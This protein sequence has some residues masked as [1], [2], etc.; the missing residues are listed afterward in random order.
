MRTRRWKAMAGA[1]AAT[2]AIGLIAGCGSDKK[3]T[4]AGTDSTAAPATDF[5]AGLVSDVGK[6]NDRSFNQS[7]LEGLQKAETDLGVK[8]KSIESKAAGDYIA[9]L[10]TLA[11]Q[12]EGV[13]IGIGFLMADAIRPT[14][15]V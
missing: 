10:T 2:A 4:A 13:S 7:G 9:N 6:F 3:S 1:V 11:R 12:K 5:T 8:I 14:C 15:A